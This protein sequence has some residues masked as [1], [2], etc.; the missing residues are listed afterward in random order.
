[1][2]DAVLNYK[3]FPNELA[4]VCVICDDTANFGGSQN[5]IFRFFLLKISSH[6]IH[7]HQVKFINAFP[8]DVCVTISLQAADKCT[9]NQSQVPGLAIQT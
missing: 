6:G 3:I 4:T 5:N 8:N 7:V 2:N 9:T 1:M